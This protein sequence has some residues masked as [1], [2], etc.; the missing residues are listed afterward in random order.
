MQKLED[1]SRDEQFINQE[2]IMP[3]WPDYY[4]HSFPLDVNIKWLMIYFLKLEM[5]WQEGAANQ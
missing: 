3:G 4:P 1:S 5:S 2:L